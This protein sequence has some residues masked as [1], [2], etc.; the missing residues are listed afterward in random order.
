[1]NWC[2]LECCIP[3]LLIMSYIG[4]GGMAEKI[5]GL[6][7]DDTTKHRCMKLLKFRW[8]MSNTKWQMLI[9]WL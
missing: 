5:W 2:K 8:E 9:G 3:S 6:D 7:K 4:I 1:M